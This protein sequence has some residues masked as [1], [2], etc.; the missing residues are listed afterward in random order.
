[1]C[2]FVDSTNP[3][4]ARIYGRIGFVGLETGIPDERTEEWAVLGWEGVDMA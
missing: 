1:V 4:P 3:V 2:L